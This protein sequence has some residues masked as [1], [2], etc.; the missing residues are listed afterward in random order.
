MKKTTPQVTNDIVQNLFH[1]QYPH[2]EVKFG[3]VTVPAGERLPAEGTNAHE[4]QEYSYLLKGTLRGE[5]NGESYEISA[6][7]ASFI[8]AGEQHWCVNE[9]NEPVELVFALV[10]A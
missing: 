8:P 3:Y 4:E 6:G 10:K 2:A 5:S 7:E 9:G 1:D